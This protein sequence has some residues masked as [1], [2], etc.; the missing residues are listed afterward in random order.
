MKLYIVPAYYREDGAPGYP[1]ELY[2]PP[3]PPKRDR[4]VY[5][6]HGNRVGCACCNPQ[7]KDDK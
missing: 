3:A 6:K 7:P 2:D 5:C 1:P 4:P